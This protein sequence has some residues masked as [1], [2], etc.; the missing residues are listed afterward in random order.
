MSARGQQPAP[1]TFRTATLLTELDVLPVDGDGAVVAGLTADD[2]EV[3]EDGEPQTVDSIEFVDVDAASVDRLP[4]DVVSNAYRTSS[5]VWVLVVDDLRLGRSLQ[6]PVRAALTTLVEGLAPADVVALVPTSGRRDQRVEF[7]LDKS[8]VLGAIGRL[9][10]V[11]AGPGQTQLGT[12]SGPPAGVDVTGRQGTPW[13]LAGPRPMSGAELPQASSAGGATEPMLDSP[14]LR[15]EAADDRLLTTLADVSRLIGQTSA[16][17]VMV[18]LVSSGL[19]VTVHPEALRTL[20]QSGL[21][22]GLR[23]PDSEEFVR[24]RPWDPSIQR[25][26]RMQQT[27]RL[28]AQAQRGRVTVYGV[29][30][31]HL[32]QAWSERLTAA[33]QQEDAR[34]RLALFDDQ[35]N[36][37]AGEPYGFLGA[38]SAGTGGRTF[39]GLLDPA[40]VARSLLADSGRYYLVRYYP[41]RQ[42]RDTRMRSVEVRVRVPGVTVRTR[43]R[44]SA[45][46]ER[47]AGEAEGRS[48]D[49]LAATV[50]E[51]LPR[52]D[53]R[54]EAL[55]RVERD[56]PAGTVVR[57]TVRVVPE[58]L[59]WAAGDRYQVLAVAIDGDGR[60]HG[61]SRG[62]F[63]APDGSPE[64][65][66][67]GH[68]SLGPLGA[69]RYQ[70]R[71]AVRDLAR[72]RT[73]SIFAD[74]TVP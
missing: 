38:L 51:V 59:V 61:A 47:P 39:T 20:D 32:S 6:A 13:P 2:F 19:P 45:A 15:A 8:T 52:T 73:G 41:V 5:R 56:A 63:V 24:M 12:P 54:L 36:P 9:R 27:V 70:V 62:T 3:V 57:L 53:L 18:V 37:L 64:V 30:P 22:D 58:G 48:S 42:A 33:T 11:E 44:Y 16:W 26:R 72:E 74:V 46:I 34:K 49:A 10:F 14:E 28:I 67:G 17:R 25:E 55:L 65:P 7:T 4:P 60:E 68:F 21:L 35:A 69:G 40:A 1:P 23:R 66:R 71:V 31:M 29:N 43:T 50:A